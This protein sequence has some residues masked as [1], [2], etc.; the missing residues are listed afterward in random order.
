M[1]KQNGDAGFDKSLGKPPSAQIPSNVVRIVRA[2]NHKDENGVPQIVYYQHGLGTDGDLEDKLLGGMT[3][4]DID[5]HIRE[6]YAFVANNYDPSTTEEL[7]IALRDG[8]KVM[9]EIVL[10]GFSRGA[11]TARAISSLITDMGLLTKLGMEQFWGIFTDWKNQD[12]EGHESEWFKSNY[13]NVASDFQAKNKRDII[14]TD[15]EYRDTL[16][17]VSIQYLLSR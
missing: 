17:L 12:V 5:E 9:D 7:D 4:F 6:A 10:L 8:S 1:A 14:F 11:Y 3:G 13:P 15:P 2:L 16:R